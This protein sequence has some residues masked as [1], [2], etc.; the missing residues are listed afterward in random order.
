MF[1]K[2]T[3]DSTIWKNKTN[4]LV[5]AVKTLRQLDFSS[6]LMKRSYKKKKEQHKNQLNMMESKLF[7]LIPYT[8]VA[9]DGNVTLDNIFSMTNEDDREL[10][11]DL[12]QKYFL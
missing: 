3:I 11:K 2:T 1:T 5:L 7:E 8:K 9:Q 10:V 4:D 6:E 12:Y